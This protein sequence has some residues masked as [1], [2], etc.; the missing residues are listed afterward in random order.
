M[1]KIK[2][3]TISLILTTLFLIMGTTYGTAAEFKFSVKPIQSSKQID[4]TL[5]YFDLLL[6]PKEEETLQ[7]ELENA[8]DKDVLVDISVNTAKTNGN[9]VVEYRENDLKSTGNLPV[10]ISKIVTFPKQVTVP[11][12]GKITVDFKVKMP[13][14]NFDG[15]LAGGIQ[16][17]EHGQELVADKD[18]K[19]AVAINNTFS[20]VLAMIIRENQNDVTSNIKLEK[21]FMK[22]EYGRSNTILQLQNNSTSYL[23]QMVI[24]ANVYREGDTEAVASIVKKEMQFAPN[25]IM[26]FRIGM[27][28]KK[29]DPGKYTVKGT[30]YGNESSIG[31]YSYDETN[32]HYRYNLEY[33]F[34]ILP[35]E[36]KKINEAN[37]NIEPENSNMFLYISIVVVLILIVVF[38]VIFIFYKKR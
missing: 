34:E 26:D 21:A 32:Y 4:K 8:T 25:S 20:Y 18:D 1:K 35:D 15:V 23:K 17:R 22:T 24:D 33:S 9:G 7:V 12:K 13:E 2:Y 3:I 27:A 36:A 16:F 11:K 6:K 37:V 38:L 10:D 30:L 28:N 19:D 14:K 5:T 29:I 31:E